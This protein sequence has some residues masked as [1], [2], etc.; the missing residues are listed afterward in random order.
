MQALGEPPAAF[1][2]HAVLR[3]EGEPPRYIYLL[4]S[5]W[6]GSSVLLPGGERQIVKF[7]LP[8]DMLG[9]PSMCLAQAADTL[10]ALT[11]VTISRVPLAAFG[12]LFASSPRFAAAMFLSVQRERVALMDRLAAV[13][14]TPAIARVAALLL[15]VEE[16]LRAMGAASDDGFDMPLTQEQIGDHLGL[17]AVHVNR[18]FRQMAETGLVSRDRHRIKLLDAARLRSM[19]ARQQRVMTRDAAWLLGGEVA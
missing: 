10:T 4:L 11:P 13:G 5:G 14:R 8:G 18:V 15:D 9:T 12:A 7:H 17:T 2:R 19:S 16:R 1:P 3:R 6:V